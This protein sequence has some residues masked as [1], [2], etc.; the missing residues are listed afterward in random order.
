M[1]LLIVAA[2]VTNCV[3][4]CSGLDGILVVRTVF[5]KVAAVTIAVIVMGKCLTR[6]KFVDGHGSVSYL[7]PWPSVRDAVS[8]LIEIDGW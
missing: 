3:V 7:E 8:E 5:T 4:C 2:I 6:S 1:V